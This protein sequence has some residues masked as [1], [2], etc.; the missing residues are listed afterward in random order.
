MIE[1]EQESGSSGKLR[2]AE[3]W[4]PQLSLGLV[5]EK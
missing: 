1:T 4:V 5:T 2:P 3:A